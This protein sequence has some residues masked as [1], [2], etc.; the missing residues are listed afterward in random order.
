MMPWEKT[1]SKNKKKHIGPFVAASFQAV[2]YGVLGNV[3]EILKISGPD[4]WLKVKVQSLYDED[5]F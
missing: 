4:A 1:P 2:A 5:V 3:D